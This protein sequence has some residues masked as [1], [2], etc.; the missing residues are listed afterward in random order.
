MMNECPDLSAEELPFRC[1]ECDYCEEITGTIYTCTQME[2]RL[3][4]LPREVHR[5][6]PSF[7]PRIP[8]R[9]EES[10]VLYLPPQPPTVDIKKPR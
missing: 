1:C 2:W 7:C 8:L 4:L 6:R 5:N 10:H 9:E 3:I